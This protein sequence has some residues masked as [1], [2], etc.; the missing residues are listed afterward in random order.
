[1]RTPDLKMSAR[2]RWVW[3]LHLLAYPYVCFMYFYD[4]SLGEMGDPDERR[5]VWVALDLMLTMGIGLYYS[6]NMHVDSSK[7]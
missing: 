6:I 7:H 4:R 1:M 2:N 5:K 3:I